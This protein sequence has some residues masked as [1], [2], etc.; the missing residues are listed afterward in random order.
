MGLARVAPVQGADADAGVGRHFGHRRLRVGQEHRAGS[1]EDPT[2]VAL[3][4]GPAAAH[5][6]PF[7][8]V[9]HPWILAME[10]SAPFC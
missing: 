8:L 5:R 1:V 10:R 9:S 2:M 6:D 7:E 4:F 3:R